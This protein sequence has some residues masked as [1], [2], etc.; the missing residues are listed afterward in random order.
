MSDCIFCG[1]AAGTMPSERVHEDERTVAF[2]DIFPAADGHVLVIP[3]AHADNVHSADAADVAACAQTA[4]LM[5]TRVSGAFGSD[6]VTITQANGA[7]AGQTV[8]HYHVHVIP[9]FDGDGILRPWTPGHAS[10][11]ELGRIGALLRGE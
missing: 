4:Q 3:R 5:A 8:F 7:A 11:E 1:I 2:L 6:G 10:P 9:R